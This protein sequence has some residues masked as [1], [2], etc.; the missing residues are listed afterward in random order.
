MVTTVSVLKREPMSVRRRVATRSLHGHK[1]PF[2]GENDV[3][4]YISK[5]VPH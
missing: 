3:L 4:A 1:G 2:S 5:H